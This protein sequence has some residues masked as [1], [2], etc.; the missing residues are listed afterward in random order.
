[1]GKDK[2]KTPK[3]SVKTADLMAENARLNAKVERFMTSTEY[4]RER[5]ID[6]SFYLMVSWTIFAVVFGVLHIYWLYE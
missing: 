2:E 3:V 5:Y 1:M 6:V 4:F